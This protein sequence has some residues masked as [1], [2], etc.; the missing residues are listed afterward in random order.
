MSLVKNCPECGS[1]IQ[2]GKHTLLSICPSC[3][4]CVTPV[5]VEFKWVGEGLTAEQQHELWNKDLEVK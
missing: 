1:F 4:K 5:E 3:R 2:V